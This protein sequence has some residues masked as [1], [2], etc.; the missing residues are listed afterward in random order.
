[1]EIDLAAKVSTIDVLQMFDLDLSRKGP[2]KDL[3]RLLPVQESDAFRR[4]RESFRWVPVETAGVIGK[5]IRC[6]RSVTT[7]CEA[8]AG[9]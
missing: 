6:T 5:F 2:V 9:P 3:S 7:S 8:F 4:C 1:M